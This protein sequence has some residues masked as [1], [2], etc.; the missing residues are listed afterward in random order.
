MVSKTELKHFEE[1]VQ[2][3]I[4]KHLI[5]GTSVAITENGKMTYSKGF[6]F[7]NIEKQLPVNEDTVFG[8][9]SIT[10]SFTCVAIMQLQESGKLNVNDPVIQYLP[11]FKW[12]DNKTIQDITIHHFMTHSS[13]LPP[14]S[15]LFYAMK[16]S[17]DSDPSVHDYPGLQIE[18]GENQP[19]DTY[20]QLMEFISEQDFE[21]EGKP[22]EH[23]SYSNEGYALLGTIIER[24]SGKLYEQYIYDHI[25]A[26]CGMTNSF[27]SITEYQDFDNI[28]TCY[29][30]KKK[31]G[32]K[33][34]YAAPVWWDTTSMR[35]AGFLKSTASD[36]L[37]FAEIFRNGGTVYGEKILS[38]Q[39]VEEMIKPHI[40]IAPGRYYGYGLM[41]TPNY[42]G[43]TL[44]EHGGAL[45]A[46]SSQLSILPER[47][48]SGVVLTN[49]AGVPSSR[50]MQLAFNDLE[51]REVKANHLSFDE[52]TLSD[53]LFSEYEGEY[54]SSEGMKVM[55]KVSEGG[56]VLSTGQYEVPI[57]FLS[58]TVFVTT[59]NDSTEVAE[60]LRDEHG[61]TS[62]I[63]YHFR[64]FP[65]VRTKETV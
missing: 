35:A 30:E 63:S 12:K 37:K 45:K 23:F 62:G 20:E 60:I 44:V 26:P 2:N 14:M 59:I 13:G 34:V 55:L 28:T 16:R 27:F 64:R 65:K 3:F 53:D 38:R 48:I 40:Q 21:I 15:S 39:S 4:E 58:D 31:D 36:L 57:T 43:T 51:G 18:Q 49:L 50:I 10:K 33:S 9:A 41:I 61:N 17:M 46:V 29:A 1:E 24:V 8:I 52:Y 6:G 7:R 32:N 11:E 42:F 56:L 22:G 54:M 5:P 19:I 25:T 47:G